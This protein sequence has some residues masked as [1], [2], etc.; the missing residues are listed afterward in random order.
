MKLKCK[1]SVSNIEEIVESTCET[2]IKFLTDRGWSIVEDVKRVKPKIE[3][4]KSK[5]KLKAKSKDKA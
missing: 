3:V 4:I 1:S 2:E 5:S